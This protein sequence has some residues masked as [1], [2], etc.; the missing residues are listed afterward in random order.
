MRFL[1]TIRLQLDTA[2][3]EEAHPYF[4]SRTISGHTPLAACCSAMSIN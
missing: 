1:L 4:A 2:R 3:I